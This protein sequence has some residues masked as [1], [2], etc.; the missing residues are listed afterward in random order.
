MKRIRLQF[1][2]L[3]IAL[4]ALAGC[5]GAATP[6]VASNGVTAAPPAAIASSEPASQ[7]PAAAAPIADCALTSADVEGPYYKAGAP[8][9]DGSDDIAP[10]NLAGQRLTL[11]GIVYD[12]NAKPGCM[13]LDGALV[14]IWQA[15][16]KG[17]YDFSDQFI[18]RG[19]VKTGADGAYQFQT[20]MPGYYEPRPLHIHLKASHPD[21]QPLTTQIY[22]A[23]DPKN[24]GVPGD[25]I[26]H[27]T[28]DGAG[29][30]ATFNVVLA[31]K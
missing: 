14:E 29:L 21:A 30:K 22:F 10:A 17:Q 25:L 18:V 7:P 9:R 28:P 2:G 27:T 15:D 23:S 16:S 13:P 8:V 1:V 3:S 4:V 19:T 5:G 6:G 11:S 31:G 12:A 24:A 20:I 26:I